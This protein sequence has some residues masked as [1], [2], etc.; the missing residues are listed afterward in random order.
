MT[1]TQKELLKFFDYNPE[2]G[3][4]IRIKG[5]KYTKRFVGQLA[6]SIT[7]QGYVTIKIHSKSHLAHR[8]AWLYMTGEWPQKFI[9]HINRIKN[10]NR[11][12]NLRLATDQQNKAN[13]PASKN[14]TSGCKGVTIRKTKYGVIRFKPMIVIDQKYIHLGTFDTLKEA[15]IAYNKAALKY[16]GEFAYQNDIDML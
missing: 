14:N 10:D 9:D 5:D 1:V 2:T 4:F 11:W 3:S 8:L 15:A 16:F 6:G 12:E 13:Q 7:K